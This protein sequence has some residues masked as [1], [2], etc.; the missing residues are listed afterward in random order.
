MKYKQRT[1][2]AQIP[3]QEQYFKTRK[4]KKYH[5]E[6]G[7]YRITKKP[8]TQPLNGIIQLTLQIKIM[9]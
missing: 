3:K 2:N 4:G 8:T 6:L 9:V 5:K 1:R 7:N